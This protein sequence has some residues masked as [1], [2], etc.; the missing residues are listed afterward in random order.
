MICGAAAEALIG[1][2]RRQDRPSR[3]AWVIGLIALVAL[4]GW[5]GRDSPF[6]VE[7]VEYRRLDTFTR[8]GLEKLHTLIATAPNGQAIS[9]PRMS[10]WIFPRRGRAT[11][12]AA[13]G[14]G[15]HS[16]EAWADL[17][18]PGRQ[19]RFEE[20]GGAFRAPEAEELVV[21]VP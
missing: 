4:G 5:W 17:T 7:Y 9:G 11:A 3:F 20:P 12:F 19:V 1:F 13:A 8:K 15:R 18:F 2:L 6:I 16:L 21:L 14:L 10:V